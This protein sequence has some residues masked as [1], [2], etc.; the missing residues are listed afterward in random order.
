MQAAARILRQQTGIAG[1]E[2]SLL[3]AL[4]AFIGFA[5]LLYG[6]GWDAE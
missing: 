2:F 1:I 5:L 4:V 3:R 6:L